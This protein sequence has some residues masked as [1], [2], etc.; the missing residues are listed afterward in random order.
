MVHIADSGFIIALLDGRD[1]AHAWAIS[2]ARKCGA[3]LLTCESAL[4]EAAFVTRRP[5]KVAAAVQA[6]DLMVEHRLDWRRIL[7]L[8][9]SYPQRMDWTDACIVFLSELHRQCRVLTVDRA[10]FAI[11]RRFRNQSIP[12]LAP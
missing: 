3:P 4:C 5:A 10:D 1:Q 8:L 9:E 6:G 2:T 7:V 11:Y 12:F